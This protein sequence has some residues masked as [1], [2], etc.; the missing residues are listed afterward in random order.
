[1]LGAN[2]A[3]AQDK[4]PDHPI[5]LI[6]PFPPGGQTDNV[7]RQLGVKI[8]P[9]L[10]QQLIIDNRSGAAGTIGSAEAA[11]AKPDG[12]TLL[13]ATTSTHAINP[14]AMANISYD[15]VR[16]FA[17]VTVLGTGPIAISVHPSVPART[18]KQ[19]VAT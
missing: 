10:G 9:I 19:L 16:D 15:A 2:A 17:P 14:T 13:V 11:R 8:A 6:V 3:Q 5:R 12:Y 18:L 1:M 7:C 4:Y